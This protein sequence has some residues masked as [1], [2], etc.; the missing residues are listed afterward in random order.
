[1]DDP[2]RRR[3]N[4]SEQR[5]RTRTLLL[6]SAKELFAQNGIAETSIE[7]ITEHAGYSRGAFYSNF[8]DK[9]AL[10]LVLI[11]RQQNA[12]IAETNTIADAAADPDDLLARLFEWF[13]DEQGTRA[14]I[15]IE[16]VLYAARNPVARLRIKELS[17][18][19]I[20]QHA[21]LVKLHHNMLDVD[22][23]IT[24]EAAAI[25]M[26]GLDEGFALLRLNDPDN[27]PRSLW[28]ETVA[29]LTEALVALAEKRAR[30][31]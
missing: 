20:A 25:V 15:D 11:E 21:H 8:D 28:S 31:S 16:Y 29:L 4:R 27:F 13:S 23:P 2:P 30:E 3:L 24:P 17:D 18:Q 22:M 5:E 19:L 9:D 7:Q 10:V 12:V 14:G 6:D 1:M 26:H